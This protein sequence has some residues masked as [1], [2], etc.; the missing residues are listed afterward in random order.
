MIFATWQLGYQPFLVDM[1]LRF[2]HWKVFLSSPPCTKT[3]WFTCL[4]CISS[5]VLMMCLIHTAH[6][7]FCWWCAWF[8]LYIIARTEEVPDL[9]LTSLLQ[10]WELFTFFGW[11]WRKW[12]KNHS[13]DTELV[14]LSNF[15]CWYGKHKIL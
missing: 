3:Y 12:P 4:Y 11:K 6:P 8:V 13:W 7:H 14:V 2:I 9:Y 10:I 5:L 1:L 15:S